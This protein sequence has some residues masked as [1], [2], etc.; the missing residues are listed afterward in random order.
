MTAAIP[1]RMNI[2]RSLFVSFASLTIVAAAHAQ[3][4]GDGTSATRRGPP[5]E[6][7]INKSQFTEKVDASQPVGVASLAT[8][9]V[10]TYW[11][12]VKN[13]K[14][15]THVTLV[16]K[17]DGKEITRQSLD[18]GLSPAWKTWGASPV[19]GAKTI[20]VDVLDE[21][22]NTLKVDTLSS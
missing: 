2:I 12:D 17:L 10:V 13:T 7:S 16:W 18:V 3:D 4:A 9:R 8:D 6:V 11:V 15:P 19:R 14:A 5:D 22:G 1:S 21:S 20:E